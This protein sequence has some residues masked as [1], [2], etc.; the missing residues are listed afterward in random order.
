MKP[1]KFHFLGRNYR[2]LQC[3]RML[4]LECDNGALSAFGIDLDQTLRE[5]VV[6]FDAKLQGM[7]EVALVACARKSTDLEIEHLGRTF[8]VSRVH[9][10][11]AYICDGTSQLICTFEFPPDEYLEALDYQ[12][13]DLHTQSLIF[14]EVLKRLDAEG[15]NEP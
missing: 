7:A 2:F 9:P 12:S 14:E 13:Q 15:G 10:C 3:D 4:I 11:K 5:A 6:E 8:R 1:I